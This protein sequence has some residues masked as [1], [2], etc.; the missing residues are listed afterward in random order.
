MH[1]FYISEFYGIY[2]EHGH[3]RKSDSGRKMGATLEDVLF[4]LESRAKTCTDSQ[5][6]PHLFI[7]D[8]VIVQQNVSL[9]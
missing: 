7:K 1:F 5:K 8:A 6:K 9:E 3:K 4:E 2:I